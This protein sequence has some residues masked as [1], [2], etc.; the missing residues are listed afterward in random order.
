M[1]KQNEPINTP[2]TKNHLGWHSNRLTIPNGEMIH[3]YKTGKGEKQ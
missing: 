1:E 3:Y 2:N